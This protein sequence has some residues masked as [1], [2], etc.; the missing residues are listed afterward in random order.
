VLGELKPYPAYKNSGVPWLEKVPGHWGVGP[1][2][3]GYTPKLTKNTG[4]AERTV[5]S[6]S[7]GQIIVKPTDKLHGLVPESFETYQIVDPGDIIVRTTDLQNDQKSLRVGITRHR[8]IITSAYMCLRVRDHMSADF[9]YLLLNAYDLLKVLYGYGSG[10][11]QNLEFS[12]IKRMPVL[13]PPRAEQ[14]AIVRFLDH[15]DR[16]IR[17]FIRAKQK[18]IKLLEEQKQAIIHRAITCGFDLDVRL[19]P[20]GSAPGFQVNEAWQVARLWQI[21]RTRSEKNRP[22]LNLLSVFLGRGVIPYGEGEGQVHKP[23][24]DLS[25]YQV[26][27]PGDL[28]L[29]NQQ[30]WRGSVGVSNYCGIISPAYLVFSL[31]SSL[32]FR[33]ADYL[34]QSRVMVA[35]YVTSSK[36]VGDIQRDIHTPWL[37]NTKVP[38]PPREKQTAIVAYLDGELPEITHQL[39]RY[40]REISLLR[41]FQTR[42]VA[43]VVIGKLDVRDVAAQLPDEPEEPEPLDEADALARSADLGGDAEPEEAEL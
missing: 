3:T 10:L 23:S 15:V 17:L 27:Y 30:A 38:I 40:E 21:V 11:R 22:E 16:R 33:F 26:V 34:F 19:K 37:M 28:V 2:F 4:M 7:Y 35:Q 6:L 36:G 32:D 29:N 18:L 9:G 39:S 13:F 42:L 1:A 25:G 20:L 14:T 43:D 24:L 12:H 5:L 8:G 41:E 31:A